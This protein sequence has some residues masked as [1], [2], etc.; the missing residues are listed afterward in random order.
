MALRWVTLAAFLATL[1]ISVQQ[2]CA[3]L[4]QSLTHLAYFPL[5]DMRQTIVIDPQRG[6]PLANWKSAYRSP[7]SLAVPT[8]GRDMYVDEAPYDLSAAKLVNP[9][10]PT[11]ESVV[12]GDSLF[13]R[14]CTPCHGRTMAGDG[15]VAASFMPPP[16][17]LAQM[18]RERKD[19]YIYQYMRHG[20][21]VMPSYG[22]AVSSHDAWDILNYIREQQRTSPR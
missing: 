3:D 11:P 1:S 21:V 2:G 12:R 17:L 7:D 9:I 18:T 22:N 15:P 14:V 6:D 5:R 4:K 8:V 16:D 20:G 19:G 13:H 10:P